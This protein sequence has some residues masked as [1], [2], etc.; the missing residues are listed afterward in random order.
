M[1]T[2]RPNLPRSR[3][4]MKWGTHG[5]DVLPLWVADLDLAPPP[6][7]RDELIKFLD[8]GDLG[9][10]IVT[11][12]FRQ[13]VATW[14]QRRYGAEL[15][16]DMVVPLPAV[17]PALYTFLL[18]F[19]E[20]GGEYLTLTPVYPYFLSAGET[21]GMAAVQVPLLKDSGGWNIDLPRLERSVT[22][23][24]RSLLL[25]H[26]HNPSGRN[27]TRAEL[28]SL[29]DFAGRHNL[30]VLS[31]EIWSDW[32]LNDSPFI[33]FTELGPDARSRTVVIGAPTKTF[34]I[35]A[36][37]VAWA[38][39]PHEGRR[40]RFQHVI[41]GLLPSPT[42]LG[43][44]ATTYLLEHGEPW[45]EGAHQLV[46]DN[47]DR[48]LNFLAQHL[49]GVRA[50]ANEATFLLW[51]DFRNTPLARLPAAE[52]LKRSRLALSEGSLF[53]AGGDGHARLN[54]GTTREILDQALWA[55]KQALDE[56]NL[57]K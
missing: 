28:E 35:P 56:A 6:G 1:E 14:Y 18:A 29:A 34:N 17:V 50:R 12:N 47:R 39:I 48:A 26:P 23:K 41:K 9:Y 57:G 31:D 4:S 2:P 21:A 30:T 38:V 19:G 22:E 32:V 3:A 5:E 55:L 7:L 44:R 45:L 10:G 16:P 40:R 11:E 27:F 36:L 42:P 52:I 24:S 37:G 25:C 46:R 15:T 54:L 53:G 33:P 49:P 20:K 8:A 13:A 43:V 51:M